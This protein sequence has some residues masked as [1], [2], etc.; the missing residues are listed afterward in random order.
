MIKVFIDPLPEME[1][2]SYVAYYKPVKDFYAEGPYQE[3]QEM[4][5]TNRLLK[6][7]DSY[8]EYPLYPETQYLIFIEVRFSGKTVGYIGSEDEP[9]T[10][11]TTDI[12]SVNEESFGDTQIYEQILKAE[13]ASSVST[14]QLD[15]ITSLSI[16]PGAGTSSKSI[17]VMADDEWSMRLYVNK[18]VTS[19]KGLRLFRNLKKLTL[20]GLD[21]T[22]LDETDF[23]ADITYLNIQNNEMSEMPDLSAFTRLESLFA[24]GNLFKP[25]TVTADKFPSGYLENNPDALQKVIDGQ[26]SYSLFV[27]EKYYE[28]ENYKPFFLSLEGAKPNREYF[29]ELTINNKELSVYS[30]TANG[31]YAVFMIPD[32]KQRLEGFDYYGGAT[33][34]VRIS[35]DLD[36]LIYEDDDV[37]V[38]FTVDEA[39]DDYDPK[40]VYTTETFFRA[41]TVILPGSLTAGDIKE[42]VLKDKDFNAVATADKY[43]LRVTTSSYDDRYNDQINLCLKYG[44]DYVRTHMEASFKLDAPLNEG[45]YDMD[46]TLN[47]GTIYQLHDV[48][49]VIE[50]PSV[51]ATAVRFV[52]YRSTMQVGETY[53]VS[54]SIEPYNTTDMASFK[55][56]NEKVARISESGLITAVGEG[57][58]KIY[59]Y[60]GDQSASF[61]LTVEDA[62]KVIGVEILSD[63][64]VFRLGSD[65]ISALIEATVIP[66]DAG[67][68]QISFSS[69]DDAV[70]I[71]D[72]EGLVTAIGEGEAEI[73]ATSVSG[74]YTDEISV[75]VLP[76]LKACV[77]YAYYFA[78]D[79]NPSAVTDGTILPVGTQIYMKSETADAIIYNADD[80]SAISGPLLVKEGENIFSVYAGKEGYLDSDA[81][82][83]RIQSKD[84]SYEADPGD[85]TLEDAQSVDMDIPED[86]WVA[87]FT[88][89][90]TYTGLKI[91]FPELRV[92]DHKTL[93]KEKTDYTVKYLNNQNVG[94]A[95][96][97]IQGKGNY[98]KSLSV[99]FMIEEASIENAAVEKQA[100][101]ETGKELM[102]NPKVIL[103]GKTLKKGKDYQI[104][105]K[106]GKMIREAGEYHLLINGI[107]NY[108]GS[109]ETVYVVGKKKENIFV[110]NLRITPEYKTIAYDGNAKEPLI[111]VF[112]GKEPLKEGVD[113]NVAYENNIEVGTAS[114]IVTGLNKYIGSK[115]LTFKITGTPLS[116]AASLLVPKTVSYTGEAIEFAKE[117]IIQAKD[118]SFDPDWTEV[119]YLKNVD[120]GTATV[121]L[122]GIKGYTGTLKKTFRI[123][124]RSLTS[125]EISA[126]DCE[127]AKTGAKAKVTVYDGKL[128]LTEGKDYV[129]TY[130]NNKKVGTAFVTVK[131]KG[132]YSGTVADVEFVISKQDLGKL[133]IQAEDVVVNSKPNKYASK[134][135]VRDLDGAALNAGKDYDKTFVYVYEED[136]EVISGKEEILRF[137][138]EKVRNTDIIPEGTLIRVSVSGTNAYYGQL[139]AVYR[140]IEKKANIA[141][142]K[143]K[144]KDQIYT[145]KPVILNKEDI[146]IILNN[147]DLSQDDFEIIRYTKNIKKGTA[148]VTLK[149]IGAYGGYK[150]ASFKIVSKTIGN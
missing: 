110:K 138:G 72:E 30:I 37:K 29:L 20:D 126:E 1:D 136:A 90:V 40:T 79:G 49:E 65:H 32:L 13:K 38:T 143:V 135:T 98:S 102:P 39:Y 125:A 116:K 140:V 64:L 128:L 81:V 97:Q 149:G 142:A 71:V 19:I 118:D 144:I 24:V 112:E 107:G 105:E 121:I 130:K 68:Q 119:S 7:K 17:D 113:Y 57:E 85:V 45:Y 62:N 83:I 77:P 123:A 44:Y 18:A 96:I 75:E 129:L 141:S 12:L 10:F 101:T 47:D 53:R 92:Y 52:N 21:L 35:D 8:S 109:I 55:S 25:E 84:E 31:H 139:S 73:I 87:G 104:I 146:G 3:S 66:E 70:A 76:P 99:F 111:T 103:D 124:P 147:I 50:K 82:T 127:Y 9:L 100:V 60:A 106:D 26:R 61:T 115:T 46:V 148:T 131:G 91:T 36:F 58:T 34:G 15:K 67:N 93:L 23:S 63:D 42:A 27:P 122:T 28:V 43:D 133:S 86:I 51:P 14:L 114:I 22:E 137:A 4:Y 6:Q 94:T 132:N 78:Q 54:Y 59:I 117:E 134:I 5:P 56:T 150:T 74:G 11:E 69:S 145:G 16:T 80:G 41:K 95:E 89:K 120:A 2:L 108:T 33:I 88:E 48:I